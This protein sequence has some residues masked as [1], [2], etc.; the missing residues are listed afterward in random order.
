MGAARKH[1]ETIE[2]PALAPGLQPR[3]P[4]RRWQGGSG[5]SVYLQAALHADEIPPLLLAHRLEAALDRLADEGRLRGSICLVPYANPIGLGQF[6]L[7][8]Q[9]GRFEL[10]SGG[11]FN[12]GFPA[13]DADLIERL[14]GRLGADP[15]ANRLAARAAI[16]DWLQAAQT[17]TEPA[18]RLQRELFALAVQ[19]DYV[20]DLHCDFEALPHLYVGSTDWP[21]LAPLAERLGAAVTLLC[22]DSGGAAFDE[23]CV[24]LYVAL[25][26]AFPEHSLGPGCRAVTVELRGERD[27]SFELADRDLAGLLEFFIDIGVLAG[28]PAA[29]PSSARALPLEAVDVVKAPATGVLVWQTELGCEVAAGAPIGQLVVP[30][31]PTTLPIIS[32]SGGLLFARRGHRWVRQGQMVAKLAADAP[33]AW[34]QSGALMYD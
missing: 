9:L 17:A 2:L 20:L 6:L 28:E 31:E 32:R 23:A 10:D 1:C 8:S 14:R 3:L 21:Q 30:G 26:K 19:H 16:G 13:C 25:A 4:L 22:D 11:N 7:G 34:R 5:P 12:R 15:A 29:P 24:Q 27:V 18:R 33:L